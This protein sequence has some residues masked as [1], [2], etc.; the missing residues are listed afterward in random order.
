MRIICLYKTNDYGTQDH[1][2]GMGDSHIAGKKYWIISQV[3]EV[4]TRENIE[5]ITS[6]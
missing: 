1:A 3:F 2:R 5:F 6:G 4:I